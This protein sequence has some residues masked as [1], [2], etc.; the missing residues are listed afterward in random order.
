MSSRAC[1]R[2]S[3]RCQKSTVSRQITGVILLQGTRESNARSWALPAGLPSSTQA[4][5]VPGISPNRGILGKYARDFQSTGV[6][7]GSDARKNP[8]QPVAIGMAERKSRTSALFV[9]FRRTYFEIHVFVD[10]GARTL[11]GFATS[12]EPMPRTRIGIS[13]SRC[14]TFACANLRR[15][16]LRLVLADSRRCRDG[17]SFDFTR[18]HHARSGFA[19]GSALGAFWRRNLRLGCRH[20]LRPRRRSIAPLAQK[21]WLFSLVSGTSRG[22]RCR[23]PAWPTAPSLVQTLRRRSPV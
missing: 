7:S 3:I 19:S 1:S 13:T 20:K 15:G 18:P 14:S 2:R 10:G 21:P 8:S 9:T 23:E 22:S 17:C 11:V 5:C 12:F 4:C 16:P 6:T